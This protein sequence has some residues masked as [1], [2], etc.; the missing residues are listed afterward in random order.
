VH[1]QGGLTTAALS[2]QPQQVQSSA[3]TLCWWLG[4]AAG[5]AR[6]WW[7]H[8]ARPDR[9]CLVQWSRASGKGVLPGWTH[10]S[11]PLRPALASA[12]QRG[13]PALV[14]RR[15]CQGGLAMAAESSRPWQ[16][17]SGVSA[18]HQR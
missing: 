16:A 18:P 1:C 14:A 6:I 5:L 7:H 4:G 15:F 12:V 2:D 9:C 17:P 11:G 13:D 8:L 3:T 10:Y